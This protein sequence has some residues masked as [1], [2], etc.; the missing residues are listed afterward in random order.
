MT[1]LRYV[2]MH[3][4]T[5]TQSLFLACIQPAA[6]TAQNKLFNLRLDAL[7][8]CTTTALPPPQGSLPLEFG[9]LPANPH[10]DSGSCLPRP[11]GGYEPTMTIS[12]RA[13]FAAVNNMF[14]VSWVGF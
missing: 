11:L 1:N 12:T 13:A 10:G 9:S 8:P 14:R 2:T 3:G 6:R 5:I 4:V 7:F